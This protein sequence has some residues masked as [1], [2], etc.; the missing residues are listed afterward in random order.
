MFNSLTANRH[1]NLQPFPLPRMVLAP[2]SIFQKTEAV[3][4]PDLQRWVYVTGVL[5]LGIL[6]TAFLGWIAAELIIKPLIRLTVA[7]KSVAEGNLHIELSDHRSGDE[8][9][10][11]CMNRSA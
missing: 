5:V 8:R 7:G 4:G 2:S 1:R 10:A 11:P 3:P 6:W 9:S